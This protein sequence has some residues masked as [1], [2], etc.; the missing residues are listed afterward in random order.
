ME[1][2]LLKGSTKSKIQIGAS[3]QGEGTEIRYI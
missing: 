1:I 2:S 3:I